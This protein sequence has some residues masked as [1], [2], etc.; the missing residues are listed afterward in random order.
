MSIDT[1][2]ENYTL[3]ELLTILDLD[4][5]YNTN[6]IMEK[7]NTYIDRYTKE[8]NGKMT[9]FFQDIQDELLNY[10]EQLNTSSDDAKYTPS[11]KQTDAWLDNPQTLEQDSS[12]QKDK[13]TDRFQKIDVYNNTHVPMNQ[14]RLGINNTYN[15]GVAQDGKLNPTLKNTIQRQIVLDSFYRQA[16][17]ETINTDYTLDLSDQLKDVLS[18]RLW[19][20]QIPMT[21]YTIDFAYGN[22]CFWISDGSNNIAIA[23]EPGNYGPADFVIA[24]NASFT[25]AGFVFPINPA[26]TYNTHNAKLTF[27]LN[28]GVYT[29]SDPADGTTAFTITPETTVFTFFNLLGGL[30][31]NETCAPQSVG[32]INQTLGWIMGFRTSI[33][34]ILASGNIAPAVLDLNGPRYLI[35][36]LDDYNQNHLNSGLVT[37]TEMSQVVK[38]PSYYSPDLPYDCITQTF[39][40]VQQLVQSS[41]RILTQPQ[42]YTINEILKN[43][44]NNLDTRL[45]APTTTDVFAI[46]PIKQGTKTGEL[47]V[48]FSGQLQDSKRTYFGPVNIDRMR[49][50]LLDDKGNLLNLNGADWAITILSENLYQY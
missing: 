15:V 37:I 28:G 41:P 5:V 17:A 32:H 48:D 14:E 42:L 31:C 12:V 8:G 9:T 21:Y 33:A 38:M 36:S 7:T 30:Q 3:A 46:I 23:V 19:S 45:K 11:H 26:V 47:Y 25:S 35:L 6:L 1:N 50:R 4:D 27:L 34:P 18:L 16:S 13:A 43:N 20:V 22:T 44:V 39:G 49:L 2:I 29:P 24:L 40:P 10:A